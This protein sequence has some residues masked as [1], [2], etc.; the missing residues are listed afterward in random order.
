MVDLSIIIPTL[1]EAE[2]V[3][4]LLPQLRQVLDRLDA[5]Y[6]IIMVDGNSSDGTQTV[7]ARN[8]ARI[9]L[10]HRPGYGNA[11][12]TGFRA[13]QGTYVL[14]MDA[15]LSHSPEFV[16]RMWEARD[17][18]E[19]LVASRYT[20]GGEAEMSFFRLALSH[21]LNA[22][23]RIGLSIPVQD[24]S[25]GFR[26]YKKSVLD[27]IDVTGVDFG[28]LIQILLSIYAQ[29]WRIE[30]IPFHYRARA[31]GKS[32]AKLLKFG[33]E[34]L[35]I[36]DAAWRMRNSI[37]FADYDERAYYSKIPL[38]RWWQR[39][40]FRIVTGYISSNRLVLDVGCGSSRIIASLPD[41][42]ALDTSLAKLRYIR[43][44]NRR[45]V[46]ATAGGL[47]F[48]SRSFDCVVCSQ[49]IEHTAETGVFAE[50]RR[51]LKVDGYLVV[52]T[53]DYGKVSWRVIEFLYGLVHRGGYADEH[54]THYTHGLIRQRLKDNGFVIQA[55]Q[56][57]GNSELIVL[58]KKTCPSARDNVEARSP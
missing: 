52:G 22:F 21:V 46:S 36:F 2:N 23:F 26:M 5:T 50:M 11:L 56:Y 6:E 19:L 13:A 49:V 43:K 38:Q 9:V 54:I 37:L 57:I 44:S 15:D 51:V 35:R 39:K 34:Y 45:L 40:R 14:T 32:H 58:A 47:P 27:S 25:S 42:I 16:L 28:V 41:A 8:H 31:T 1:N 53:P 10:Q 4:V 18:A 55:E 48:K 29:G 20:R 12:R 7:A 3:S 30:E 24:M 17:R 33:V